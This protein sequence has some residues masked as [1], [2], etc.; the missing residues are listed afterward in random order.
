MSQP[1]L[2]QQLREARRTAGLSI[3]ELARRSGTSRAAIHAYEAGTVSP[4]LET[5]QRIL[6][7]MGYTLTVTPL[8]PADAVVAHSP[9]PR[10]SSTMTDPTGSPSLPLT[11][12]Q[13]R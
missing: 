9:R 2:N 13:T 1:P 11:K 8:Q 6:A 7:A 12:S 10:D 5:T 4:S 3:S